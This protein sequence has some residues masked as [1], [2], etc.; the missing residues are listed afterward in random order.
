MGDIS[1]FGLLNTG[2]LGVYTHKLAMGVVGHNIAN[3]S[4]PGYSRQNPIIVAT[5]P[6]GASTLTQP[7]MPLQVGTGS[8]VKDITRIRDQFLDVQYRGVVSKNSYWSSITGNM[9]YIEQLFGEPGDEKNPT[10]LRYMFDQFWGSIEE[11]KTDPT[12]DAAKGQIVARASEM[13]NVMYD[14]NY[15]LKELQGDI[16]SE[17]DTRVDQLNVYF[18]RI[19]DLN[20]KIKSIQL[21]GATPNDLLDERDRILDEMSSLADLQ[22]YTYPSGEISL[23]IGDRTLLNGNTY[24]EL[25]TYDI[26]GTN[27]FKQIFANNVPVSFNDGKMASLFDLRDEIIHMYKGKIDEFALGL[28]DTVN[29]VYKEGWDSTGNI[30]GANFFREIGAK[31]DSEDNRLYRIESWKKFSGGPVNFVSSSRKFRTTGL[32]GITLP[33]NANGLFLFDTSVKGV[34]S[35]SE[36]ADVT[37]DSFSN[38][39]NG[40]GLD[41]SY[42]TSKDL[43]KMSNYGGAPIND[44]LLIDFN[45]NI[46]SKLGFNTKNVNAFKIDNVATGSFDIK[47]FDG[48]ITNINITDTTGATKTDQLQ[49]M[50]DE[51]NSTQDT[52]RAFVKDES[53]YIVATKNVEDFNIDNVVISDPDGVMDD[54]G[55]SKVSLKALDSS[56]PTIENIF[57]LYSLNTYKFEIPTGAPNAQIKVNITEKDGT[58]HTLNSTDLL[59]T[60]FSEDTDDGLG[61]NLFRVIKNGNYLEVVPKNPDDFNDI[62]G[63]S[64]VLD[65]GVTPQSLEAEKTYY[66]SYAAEDLFVNN[67]LSAEVVNLYNYKRDFSEQGINFQINGVNVNI[68]PATETLQDLVNKI[69]SLN[70]GMSAYLTPNGSF[71][72]KAGSSIDFNMKNVT[73]NGPQKFFEL[74]G[75]KDSASG[76]SYINYINSDTKYAAFEKANSKADI[77]KL[78][79]NYSVIDNFQISSN[80]LE[81]PSLLSIDLGKAYDDNQDWNADRFEPLG[82]SSVSVWEELSKIK[83]MGVLNDG[84]DGFSGF[85]SSLVAEMGIRGE[86]AKKM[87]SNS[88]VLQTNISSERERVKGVSL[89]EEMSNMIKYQQAFNASARLI[90]AVDEMISRIVN[91]LGTVGR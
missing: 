7:S 82:E 75:L 74:L 76:N 34:N 78:E 62:A 51:I 15:R 6:M 16:N 77:L 49:S 24:L 63:I 91:N 44:R 5:P 43:L 64:L 8:K 26:P 88:E 18:K 32:S 81:N 52:L 47:N 61:N 60:F 72:L 1:L 80:L 37:L 31:V 87:Q 28:I 36:N 10:G 27:G 33:V 54:L 17:I 45:N 56:E 22:V 55:T 50:A 73:I 57:N 2:M 3:A 25:K 38:S 65:D 20:S 42:N 35:H 40:L 84:K 13:R 66:D 39:L 4:T 59:N 46:F 29:L 14:L 9:H 67:G 11:L 30:T 90:T 19:A 68:D 21:N 89:D 48:T 86:T 58:V 70:T 41:L 85:L 23:R 12:N 71:V 53:M 79:K 83:D 69:N